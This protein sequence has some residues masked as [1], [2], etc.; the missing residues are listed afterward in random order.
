MWSLEHGLD[1]S[2][3]FAVEP[4]GFGR[5][6]DDRVDTAPGVPLDVAKALSEPPI[7]DISDDEEVDV[8]LWMHARPACIRAMDGGRHDIRLLSE[9]SAKL[10]VDANRSLQQVTQR[11]VERG[12]RRRSV[13]LRSTNCFPDDDARVARTG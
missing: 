4:T 6:I 7:I 1:E 11:F 3:A 5:R 9:C 10:G 12:F 8:A 13:E 2:V